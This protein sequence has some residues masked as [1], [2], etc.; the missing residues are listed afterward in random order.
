MASYADVGSMAQ[1]A[2]FA[3]DPSVQYPPMPIQQPNINYSENPPPGVVPTPDPQPGPTSAVRPRL[4]KACDAC[5]LRKVK[6]KYIHPS[7][8]TAGH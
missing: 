7:E 1:Q 3:V 4:R 5:S 8:A 6:V 2:P